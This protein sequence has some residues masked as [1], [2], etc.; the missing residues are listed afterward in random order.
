MVSIRS[1]SRC[2]TVDAHS[3]SD[4]GWCMESP[5]K[6]QDKHRTS[7]GNAV[8]VG[9]V[10]IVWSLVIWS[11]DPIVLMGVWL[12]TTIASI[13]VA[14]SAF[15]AV[16]I[17]LCCVGWIWCAGID[18]MCHKTRCCGLETPF[19]FNGPMSIDTDLLL[20]TR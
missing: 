7:M 11:Q 15:V 10:F 16:D 9:V 5:T 18:R 6:S 14:I 19:G 4:G 2:S 12:G 17:G 20:D 1:D 3:R 8:G 13:L